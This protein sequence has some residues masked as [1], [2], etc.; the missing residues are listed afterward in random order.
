MGDALAK[1]LGFDGE[2]KFGEHHESHAAS[3]FYPSPFEEAAVVTMDG[4]GEWATSSIGVGRGADLQLL[5]TQAIRFF[6]FFFFFFFL[7]R[8]ASL[9]LLG[10]SILLHKHPWPKQAPPSV[11]RAYQQTACGSQPD[12]DQVA[13]HRQ[14]AQDTPDQP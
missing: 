10:C 12:A 9:C 13:S 7:R 3:A 5:R 8:F 6:F 14:Q 2:V 1:E 11:A 4:V